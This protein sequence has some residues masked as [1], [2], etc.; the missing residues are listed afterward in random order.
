MKN[1][2]IS[3]LSHHGWI[4]RL[5]LFMV[6][7]E[8]LQLNRQ[9]KKKIKVTS[10]DLKNL[11]SSSACLMVIRRSKYCFCKKNENER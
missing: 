5:K 3:E 4:E 6:D 7:I 1:G 9:L 8:Y 11:D 2:R 10:C